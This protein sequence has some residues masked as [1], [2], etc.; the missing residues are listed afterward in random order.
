M[1]TEL[2]LQENRGIIPTTMTEMREFAE[3]VCKSKLAPKGF[4]TPEAVIIAMQMGAEL[5]LAPMASL[6]NIAVINGKPCLYGDAALGVVRAS[7]LLEVFE[8]RIER[9]KTEDETA[10]FCRLQRKGFTVHEQ[11]FSVAMAKKAGLWGKSGPWSQYPQRMLQMRARS[12]A[13][14]DQFADVLKGMK[15]AEEVGDYQPEIKQAKVAKQVVLP[16]EPEPEQEPVM[17]EDV[18]VEQEKDK[19]G[20]FKF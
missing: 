9:G 14:R 17:I 5:G 8:E 12:F 1:N 10:A 6:Q 4:E 15:L 19:D 20:N 7:G 3:T 11:K 18:T 16:D 13:L 2:T